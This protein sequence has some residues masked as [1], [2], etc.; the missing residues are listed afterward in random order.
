MEIDLTDPGQREWLHLYFK[1]FKPIHVTI[2][3]TAKSWDCWIISSPIGNLN[4]YIEANEEFIDWL[5]DCDLFE[6][7]EVHG[8]ITFEG[9]ELRVPEM[10]GKYVIGFDTAHFRDVLAMDV[11]PKYKDILPFDQKQWEIISQNRLWLQQDVEE[12][13]AKLATQLDSLYQKAYPHGR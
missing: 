9:G 11:N 1:N 10:D 8:G 12:E 5:K 3:C 2:N 7:L 4:G 6:T 13:L